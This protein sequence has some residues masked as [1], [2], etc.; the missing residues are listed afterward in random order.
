M[1]WQL[2]HSEDIDPT[3]TKETRYRGLL[4]L[5]MAPRALFIFNALDDGGWR[6]GDM[7]RIGKT[8]GPEG[9]RAHF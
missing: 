9:G 4:S 6:G 7:I 3:K 5:K 1:P 2:E 8:T